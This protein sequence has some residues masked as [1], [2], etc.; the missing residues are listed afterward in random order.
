MGPV[1]VDYNRATDF[2]CQFEREV[3]HKSPTKV[4]LIYCYFVLFSIDLKVSKTDIV[5]LGSI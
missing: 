2:G 3:F 1:A 4:R 5:N